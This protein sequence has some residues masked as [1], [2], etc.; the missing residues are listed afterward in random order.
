MLL[1]GQKAFGE[2]GDKDH[3]PVTEAADQIIYRINAGRII[4][5]LDISKDQIGCFLRA[6]GWKAGQPYQQGTHNFRVLNEWN[7][8]AVYQQAIALSAAAIDG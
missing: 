7:A 3:R 5:Q 1:A 8:A 2:G 4:G 6:K